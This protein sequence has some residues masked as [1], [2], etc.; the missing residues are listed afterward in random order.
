MIRL[1]VAQGCLQAKVL[2]NEKIDLRRAKYLIKKGRKMLRTNGATS[3][4]IDIDSKTKIDKYAMI[5]VN[6]VLKT[7]NTYPL[8]IK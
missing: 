4:S 1:I 5:F 6:K 2:G 3:I 7:Y 8:V